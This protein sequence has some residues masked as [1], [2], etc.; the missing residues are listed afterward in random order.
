VSFPII[1]FE[2]SDWRIAL[3]FRCHSFDYSYNFPV[4]ED[5]NVWTETVYGPAPRRVLV[6]DQSF[7]THDDDAKPLPSDIRQIVR[8]GA[9][10]HYFGKGE[11]RGLTEINLGEQLDA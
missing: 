7:P 5:G 1:V 2:H 3:N 10:L 11:F 6:I 4:D 8:E 9:P